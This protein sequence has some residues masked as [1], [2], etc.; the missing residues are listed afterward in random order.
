MFL[1]CFVWEKRTLCVFVW[2]FLCF[3]EVT[4]CFFREGAFCVLCFV[5]EEVRGTFCVSSGKTFVFFFWV[6]GGTFCVF[7]R[8]GGGVESVSFVR[9]WLNSCGQVETVVEEGTS[10]PACL[11]ETKD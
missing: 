6:R 10:W 3:L 11:V 2:T 5:W 4:I 7:R 9:I 1:L 8:R